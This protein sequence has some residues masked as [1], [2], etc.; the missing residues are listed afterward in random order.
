MHDAHTHTV[1]FLLSPLCP[2]CFHA[3]CIALARQYSSS[4]TQTGA[5]TPRVTRL[6]ASRTTNACIHQVSQIEE[7]FIFGEDEVH[8]LRSPRPFLWV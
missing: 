8:R 7:R 6:P 1:S 2:P 3:L 5:C 4:Q